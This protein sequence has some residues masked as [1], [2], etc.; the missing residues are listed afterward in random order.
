MKK[1]IIN[2]C[3]IALTITCLFGL[4]Y[5]WWI[6]GSLGDGMII[7]SAKIDSIITL[8]KG[9][10]NNYDGN[11]NLDS[12]GEKV[13]EEVEK[14]NKN[15]EQVLVLDFGNIIPSM[16][17]TWRITVLNKGDVAGYVYATLY[18]EIDFSDGLSK[19]EEFIKYM[20]I[21]T[22]ITDGEGNS[23]VNK[24]YLYNTNASTVLFGGTEN[25]KVEINESIQI[26]FQ[27]TFEVFDDLVNEGILEESDRVNYQALQG[28]VLSSSFKFLDVSLSS[29]LPE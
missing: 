2:V 3:S 19:E 21:S 9:L 11:L 13:F 5:A 18:E 27:I 10:D 20:S 25:E 26:E 29:A 15:T 16:V 7:K 6:T 28:K 22:I 1:I 14:T 24:H 23:V 8:E 4:T 12:I 17:N